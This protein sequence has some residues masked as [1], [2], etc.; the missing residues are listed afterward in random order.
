MSGRAAP[1]M[2]IIPIAPAPGDE[3]VAGAC[4]IGPWEIRRRRAGALAA[5][6]A[7]AV[8]FV[9]LV[10]VGAPAWTRLVLL[11]PLWGGFVSWLQARRRFCVAFAMAG[12]ANF[13]EGES[14]RRSITDT[15]QRDADRR[16]TI[17]LL[18]DALLL[19]LVLTI[20]AVVVP[21]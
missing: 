19:A 21:A 9:L 11:L 16:A 20:L 12:V 3:Y 10:A 8:L 13:G 1:T 18:R 15:A 4:N 17:V 5:F 2:P 14:S 7:A 6:A